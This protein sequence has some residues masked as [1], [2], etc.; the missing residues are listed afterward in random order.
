M[1]YKWHRSIVSPFRGE[2][3]QLY[4][5]MNTKHRSNLNLNAG[6][7]AILG[8]AVSCS[9]LLGADGNA[10]NLTPFG[11]GKLSIDAINCA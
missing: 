8:L 2:K 5:I 4:R 9:N 3:R 1:R 11:E 7:A 10:G 6:I